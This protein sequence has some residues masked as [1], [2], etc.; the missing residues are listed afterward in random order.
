MST[1]DDATVAALVTGLFSDAGSLDAALE[2]LH[3]GER[4][5]RVEIRPGQMNDE[6]WDDD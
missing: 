1:N 4:V 2:S 3:G 6:D 5:A